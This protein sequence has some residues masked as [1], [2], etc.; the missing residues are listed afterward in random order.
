MSIRLNA[1]EIQTLLYDGG[2]EPVIKLAALYGIDGVDIG[3][4]G[5]GA[6]LAFPVA[7]VESDDTG[8]FAIDIEIAAAGIYWARFADA[9]DA[10][11]ETVA[12]YAY[13]ANSQPDD[14]AADSPFSI[15]TV[16][17]GSGAGVVAVHLRDD[18]GA[19]IGTDGSGAAIV[20]PQDMAQVAGYADSWY[21]LDVTVTDGPLIAAYDDGAATWV[22][23]YTVQVPAPAAATFFDGWEPDG[24]F[25]ADDWATISYIRTRT[26]WPSTCIADQT[27]RELRDEAIETFIRETNTWYPAWRGTWYGLYSQ[28]DRLYL[29][30]PIVLPQDGGM[31]PVVSVYEPWGDQAVVETLSNTDL[32]WFVRPPYDKQPYLVTAFGSWGIRWTF[33]G[34]WRVKIRADWGRVGKA[35]SMPLQVRSVIVGLV[36]WHSL[37]YGVGADESRDQSTLNRITR[38]ATRDRS[39]TYADG[40]VGVGITG[41]RVI[42]GA[43]DRMSVLPGPWA[44][45][46]DY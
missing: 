43:L 25:D 36:R 45:P 14:F 32:G 41:D 3:N 30:Q 11:I 2:A 23:T 12:I 44:M 34:R 29:P 40:S 16:R 28:T 8:V 21:H 19:D 39:V 37:A 31:V 10:H 20:W 22:E 38:E 4:D 17:P 5:S 9:A 13:T 27:I 26:G 18:G 33:S 7:M 46:R 1:A 15:A 42:D 24:S 35:R 6:P